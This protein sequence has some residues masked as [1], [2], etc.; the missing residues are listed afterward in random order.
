MTVVGP[1]CFY[2]Q[3]NPVNGEEEVTGL[4]ILPEILVAVQAGKLGASMYFD[5]K[6][7]SKRLYNF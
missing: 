1:F 7:K 3:N 4:D 2:C 6:P 5:L